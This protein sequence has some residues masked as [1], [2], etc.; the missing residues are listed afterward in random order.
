MNK[1]SLVQVKSDPHTFVA[2]KMVKG[3]MHT[4]ILPTYVDNLFPI[5]DKELTD[6][7]EASIGNYFDITP[8]SMFTISSASSQTRLIS[9]NGCPLSR[10]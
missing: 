9:A 8:L 7:F 5:G 4:L 2:Q 3:V 10:D 1:L 6:D